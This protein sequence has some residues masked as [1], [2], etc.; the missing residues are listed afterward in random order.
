[1]KFWIEAELEKGEFQVCK[2]LYFKTRIK[3]IKF[4]GFHS[5]MDSNF[6]G[7]AK[8]YKTL[9]PI[10]KNHNKVY[11][12]VFGSPTGADNSSFII[13][14][15]V[16]ELIDELVELKKPKENKYLTKYLMRR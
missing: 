2:K 14:E 8:T 1:M 5:V 12:N 3:N 16:K 6:L 4:W 13:T 11:A 10:E 7:K 15:V 9:V